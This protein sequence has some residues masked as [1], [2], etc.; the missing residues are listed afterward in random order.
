MKSVLLRSLLVLSLGI[1][2]AFSQAPTPR[3]NP[4]RFVGEITAF[5]KQPADTGGIVFTGSSS[6]RLWPRLNEDFP[7]L[8]I[9]NRGF[10]GSVAND[11]IVYFETVITRHAPKL[12]V[13]YTG[14]NDLHEKLSVDE[15]LNDYTSFLKM[16]HDRFPQTRIILT[17]VKI[18]PS[19][20]LEIPSV[21]ALNVRLQAWCTDKNWLRY[22]DCT[23]YLADPQGQPMVSFYRDDRLHLSDAGYAQWKSILD[24]VLREEWAKA[25]VL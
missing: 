17:S 19:R 23:S 14:G 15:A 4:A 1:S 20:D 25:G 8:P 22:I 21:H 10:G 12:V 2:S 24:P 13:V 5:A 3:P 6:I 11:L 16:V 9:V 7:G 18:A